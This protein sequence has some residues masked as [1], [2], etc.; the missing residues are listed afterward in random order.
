MIIDAASGGVN[1]GWAGGVDGNP[2]HFA[3]S[4]DRC[5]PMGYWAI[6]AIPPK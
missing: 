5:A 3:A 4:K 6:A 2:F 1:K